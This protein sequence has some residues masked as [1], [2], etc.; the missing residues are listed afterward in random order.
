MITLS[1]DLDLK[2]L[3]RQE[4]ERLLSELCDTE[5]FSKKLDIRKANRDR[6]AFC[7]Y[8]IKDRKTNENVIQADIHRAIQYAFENYKKVLIEISRESGKTTQSIAGILYEIGKRLNIL[9]KIIGASDSLATKRVSTIKNHIENNKQFQSVYPDVKPYIS[10][11]NIKEGWGSS[12]ITV[13][14]GVIDPNPTLQACGILSTGVGDRADL[15]VFDDPCDL[16]NS[17]LLPA[18]REAVIQAYEN[19]WVPL[20]GNEGRQWYLATPWHESDLTSVLKDRWKDDP[21]ACVIQFH[22]GQEI[23]ISEEGEILSVEETGDKFLPIWERQWNREQLMKRHGEI[24]SRSYDRAYLC[25]AMA[26]EDMIFKPVWLDEAKF[27]GEGLTF[28]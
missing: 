3:D 21:E 22:V 18:L 20:L 12:R 13:E 8:V 28:V 26:D 11:Y 10:K 1:E 17:I 14:R 19:V 24:G 2:K 25:K 15:L 23:D 4:R 6:N 27:K 5:N 16:R 7:E 9:I